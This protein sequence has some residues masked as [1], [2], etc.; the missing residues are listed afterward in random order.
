MDEMLTLPEI[1]A[2]F[3]SEWVLLADPE[4]DK[5]HRVCSGRLLYHSKDRAEVLSKL[6]ELRPKKAAFLYT[7][8]ITG[9]M[10]GFFGP[11][12]RLDS[13]GRLQGAVPSAL[14]TPNVGRGSP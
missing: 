8:K 4:K 2:R 6:M 14:A 10:I 11:V 9:A 7:G 1:E 13:S 12:R 5:G 3:P